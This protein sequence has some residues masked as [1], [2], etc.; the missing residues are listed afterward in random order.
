MRS[1][2]RDAFV[3]FTER[4][5]G[6][7]G[8]MYL[9][10]KGLVTVAIGNLIDPLPLALGCPFVRNS[11]GQ[12][13]TPQEIAEEW[14]RVKQHDEL[15]RLG[16]LAAKPYTLLHLTPAGIEEVV[17][18]RLALNVLNLQRRFPEFDEWP[19]DAQLAT[20]SM[21][22]ACG[23]NFAFPRLTA[24]LHRQD[25]TAAAV[26]CH[27]EDSHNPG[28]RPRNAANV[29]LYRNAAC[30]AARA[31]D[32][33][34]LWYPRELVSDTAPPPPPPSTEPEIV[35]VDAGADTPETD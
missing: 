16:H 23:A 8:W 13:A 21:A 19:A 1:S 17:Q 34:E 10:V 7:V 3:Q 28:V 2:V 9:D 24:A 20:L 22:W 29:T 4:F 18:K 35:D 5:E 26:E 12:P 31:W 33:E 6:S 27:I 11:D 14:E 15:A 32:L 25:W 30:V